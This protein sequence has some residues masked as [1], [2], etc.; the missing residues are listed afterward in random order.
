MTDSDKDAYRMAGNTAGIRPGRPSTHSTNKGG[1]EQNMNQ[2]KAFKLVRTRDVLVAV[3]LVCGL[4]LYGQRPDARNVPDAAAATHA[5]SI[6]QASTTT[7]ST[8]AGKYIT[9]DVPG[10]VNS[11]TPVS[12]NDLGVITGSYGDNIGSDYH[13]FIRT[14]WG[15]FFTFDVPGAVYGTFPA[16]INDFG[17]ITG[18]YGDNI[19]SGYHGFV[20]TPWGAFVTFDVP[21][22]VYG[23]YPSAMNARGDVV[24]YYYDLN[25]IQHSFLRE[26]DGSLT[27]FDPPGTVR[28]SYATTI[29]PDGVILGVYLHAEFGLD[30]AV[31]FRRDRSGNFT[32]VTGPGGLT[33]QDGRDTSFFGDVLSVNP[34][35]EI[36]GSYFEPITG[37]PFGGDFQVFLLSKDGQYTTFAAA[38]YP[39]CCIFS[40]P[41]SISPTGTVTGTL[42]DGLG[43]YR[44]FVRTPDGTLTLLDAP[45]AGTGLFQGTATIGITPWGLVA[46]VYVGPSGGNFFGVYKSHGFLWLPSR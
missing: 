18:S 41:T 15:S 19:G 14:I 2:V 1:K 17:A 10:D 37:N 11:T 7:P 12:I 6:A 25:F 34:Q 36:A 9:F 29:T 4:Q 45:G 27:T 39:P 5:E 8:A 43:I 35:G 33:G 13:G 42:N 16:S 24:G 38:D 20:R 46:G 21:D 40:S 3:L 26:A 30:R 32:E 31:G 28:G 22:D 23:I 44:G